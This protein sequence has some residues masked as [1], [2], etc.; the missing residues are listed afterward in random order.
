[1]Y[2]FGAKEIAVKVHSVLP[3][4][5]HMKPV[6]HRRHILFLM[7][8]FEI[9]EGYSLYKKLKCMKRENRITI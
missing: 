2:R 4:I 8:H 9:S 1:M 3:P 5:R 7:D 6:M